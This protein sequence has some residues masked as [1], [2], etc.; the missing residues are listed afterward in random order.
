MSV[1]DD[2]ALRAAMQTYL[3]AA[4]RLEDAAE[5][6][7]APGTAAQSVLDLAETK[8]QAGAELT[9]RLEMLGWT[10]PAPV[11]PDPRQPPV[12]AVES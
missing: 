5:D 11:T 1:F 2:P 9:A 12:A 4:E 3:W 7:R 10:R 8:A 6:G